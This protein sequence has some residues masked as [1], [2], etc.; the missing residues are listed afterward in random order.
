MDCEFVVLDRGYRSVA[1]FLVEDA[2]ANTEP[3][4]PADVCATAR[5]RAGFNQHRPPAFGPRARCGRT[6]QIDF[7]SP[8]TRRK[9]GGPSGTRLQP[10]LGHD[11]G[12]LGRQF[13][14]E[15][16]TH[17]TLPLAVDAAVGGERYVAAMARPGQPDIG[18]PS[19]LFERGE[20][21][22]LH[23]ALVRK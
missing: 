21:V 5:D 18:E 3:A 12:M 1:E 15:A 13:V 7:G 2:I 6:R 23:R 9:R 14:D 10:G 16:R 11:L 8:A 20:P 22:L 4:D 17:R 19:L